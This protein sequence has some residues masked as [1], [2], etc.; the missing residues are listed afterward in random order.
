MEKIDMFY[1][2]TINRDK[3]S[4]LLKDSMVEQYGTVKEYA[5]QTKQE[6][7]KVQSWTSG[8]RLP[9]L[10]DIIATCNILEIPLEYALVGSNRD[11]N[12]LENDTETEDEYALKARFTYPNLLFADVVLLIPLMSMDKLMD[13]IYR[14]I[15]CNDSFYVYNLFR[16]S[17]KN[18]SAEWKYCIYC[19]QQRNSPL[20]YGVEKINATFVETL[21]WQREYLK[22]K[23]EFFDKYNELNN[24]IYR[25]SRLKP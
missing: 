13:I 4:K 7:K 23:E 9:E 5:R 17:I 19:L 16:H 12:Y 2:D 21:E 24:A 25:L 22:K 15:D 10:E 20:I 18:E 3:V 8:K 1:R 14:V 11:L 6:Y